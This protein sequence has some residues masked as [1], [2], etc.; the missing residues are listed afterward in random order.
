MTREELGQLHATTVLDL[1]QAKLATITRSVTVKSSQLQVYR[2]SLMDVLSNIR[3]LCQDKYTG[4][5]SEDGISGRTR[6]NA[7]I[8]ICNAIK[9]HMNQ[10][11]ERVDALAC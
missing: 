5:L 9:E 7:T 4:L 11:H 1:Y 10:L 6:H 8:E 3:S 2:N